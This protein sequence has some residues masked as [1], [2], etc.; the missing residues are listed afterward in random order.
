MLRVGVQPTF[1]GISLE[2]L[3]INPV[4]NGVDVFYLLVMVGRVCCNECNRNNCK[5]YQEKE[6]AAKVCKA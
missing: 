1:I 6:D 3:D 5:G 4:N 2:N